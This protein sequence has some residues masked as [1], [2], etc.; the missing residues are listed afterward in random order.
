MVDKLTPLEIE[1]FH[2]V[3]HASCDLIARMQDLTWLFYGCIA[4]AVAVGAST[5][6]TAWFRHKDKKETIRWRR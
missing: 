4:L 2:N 6:L 3:N 5:A 1:C